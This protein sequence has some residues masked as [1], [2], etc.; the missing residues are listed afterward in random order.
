MTRARQ[1]DRGHP[2]PLA[3]KRAPPKRAVKK[4]TKKESKR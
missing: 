2:S 3:V 4:G 1:R